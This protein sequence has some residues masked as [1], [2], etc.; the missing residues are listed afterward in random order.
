MTGSSCDGTK[1]LT[2]SA[3]VCNPSAMSATALSTEV[4][5]TE[6]VTVK[7]SNVRKIVS[8]K[9]DSIAFPTSPRFLPSFFPLTDLFTSQVDRRLIRFPMISLTTKDWRMPFLN[10]LPITTLK[11][12]KPFIELER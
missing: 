3:P 6:P 9:E 10:F 4:A 2:K 1:R 5:L 7:A 8:G 11:Y 12:T